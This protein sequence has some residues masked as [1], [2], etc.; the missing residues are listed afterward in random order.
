MSAES[1]NANVVV[2]SLEERKKRNDAFVANFKRAGSAMK[3]TTMQTKSEKF[4]AFVLENGWSMKDMRTWTALCEACKTCQSPRD[5]GEAMR[6]LSDTIDLAV[7]LDVHPIGLICYARAEFK[8][9]DWTMAALEVV[10]SRLLVEEEAEEDV[11]VDLTADEDNDDEEE[12][13]EEDLNPK[14]KLVCPGAP[15]RKRRLELMSAS[16]VI[17]GAD[18][19]E[20]SP[21]EPEEY[22]YPMSNTEYVEDI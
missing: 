13:V 9:F 22:E 21:P 7:H 11:V 15:S 20:Y 4:T 10:R 16:G 17:H 3:Q 5:I 6:L 2:M 12:T 1:K 14:A 8:Q 18:G 19:A